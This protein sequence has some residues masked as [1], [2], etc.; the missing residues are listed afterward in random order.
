MARLREF[1]VDAV[2][3]RAMQVFWAEGY[4]RTSL[5]DL[6][7]AMQLNRSS[8]YGAF[9]DKRSLFL[10]TIDRYGE[11]TVR[12][13]SVTFSGAVPIRKA[14]AGFFAEIIDQ[15]AVE[16][17]RRGCFLGNCAAEV[18]QRDRAV[19]ARVR[20]NLDRLEM[21]YRNALAHA[22]A[23]GEIPVHSDIVALARFFVAGAQGLHL[24]GW[25]TKDREVLKGAVEI[26]LR[27]LEH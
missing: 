23:R 13:I 15:I 18:A 7:E 4:H 2:L 17:G 5:S 8:L 26:M 27:P 10:Q 19:A 1:D 25:T 9:G 16:R 24:I 20:Y 22:K 11:R 21:I 12:R 6:C 3:D 14:A